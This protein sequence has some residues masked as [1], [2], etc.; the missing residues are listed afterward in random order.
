MYITEKRVFILGAGSSIAISGGKFP[1]INDF[2]VSAKSLGLTKNPEFEEIKNY[3]HKSLGIKSPG[4]LNIE[5]LFTHIEIELERY[6][7]PEITKIRLQLL[8]LIREVLIGLEENTSINLDQNEVLNKKW[9]IVATD[10]FITF[11]WDLLLD[12]IFGRKNILDGP[13]DTPGH[14]QYKQYDNFIKNLSVHSEFTWAHLS[15][16]DPYIKWDSNNG[17]ILKLHGS[18]DWFSCINEKC[19][20]WQ[21]VF[22]LSKPLQTYYCSECHEPLENLLIPP[23]LNK[24]YRQYSFIRRIWNLAAQE[25]RSANEIIIWGY[26]LPTT[27]FYSKWLLRQG[28]T[29][30]I[31]KLVIINPFLVIG[32]KEKKIRRNFLTFFTEIFKG[33]GSLKKISLFEDFDDYCEG[34][35]IPQK[36]GLLF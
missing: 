21:K 23:I 19:R 32:Q 14:S 7:S 36:Y 9:K 3:L 26:S 20:A 29:D 11:N 30:L 13:R 33:V 35:D 10:T 27:D 16:G 4:M 22:P 18:V 25:V 1:S 8:K 31:E 28:R 24:T 34:L 17:F 6:N 2:F 12:N 15:I 5:D